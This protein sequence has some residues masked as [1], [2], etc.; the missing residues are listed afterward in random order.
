MHLGQSQPVQ[1][2]RIS[3]IPVV[4]FRHESLP[5]LQW[6]QCEEFIKIIRWN[7]RGQELITISTSTTAVSNSSSDRLAYPMIYL[8]HYFT[9]LIILPN[10]PP[11]HGTFGMLNTH[12]TPTSEKY[13]D[14]SLLV[15]TVL[16]LAAPLNVLQLS[17]TILLGSPHLDVATEERLSIH[18]CNQIKVNYPYNTT[19][20]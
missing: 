16:S 2:F 15:P 1:S 14:T 20:V 13:L 12:W 5:N 19:H 8:K 3:K 10:N 4:D 9:D 11:H 7:I 17:G 18:V 6:T